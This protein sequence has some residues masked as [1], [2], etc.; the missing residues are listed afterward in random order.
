MQYNGPSIGMV[1]WE[2]G[3]VDMESLIQQADQ[4]MYLVKQQRKAAEKG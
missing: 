4:A 2:P 3:G 1:H